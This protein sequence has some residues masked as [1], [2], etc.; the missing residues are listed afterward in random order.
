ML[1]VIDVGNTNTKIGVCEGERLLVSWT[2]TTRRE[3]TADEYG[4][5]TGTLLGTRGIAPGDI[6]G[7]AIS[8]VVPPVQ[9]ALERMAEQYFGVTAFSVEPGVNTSLPLAVDSPREVGPDRIVSVVAAVATYG[10]PLIVVDLGTATR[11]DCVNARGE[12]IGGA[13]AP[14]IS[15]ALDALLNRA[16]RLFRVELVRPKEAIGRNTVTN[17]QSGVVYGYAGLVDGLVERMKM[18]MGGSAKV[19]ATGGLAPLIADVARS[20]EHVDPDLKLHGLRLI[21][22]RAHA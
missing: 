1:L 8:N 3:Q 10:A 17:I 18:E 22:R 4:V 7:V 11:F 21:Y 6:E 12:F 15:V 2:L 13:I 20:I 9:Q 19:V 16:A 5:F 14:G